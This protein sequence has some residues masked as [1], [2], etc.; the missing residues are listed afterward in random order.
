M[1]DPRVFT[2]DNG[3]S[4]SCINHEQ[5]ASSQRRTFFQLAGKVG[6]LEVLNDIGASS[7]GTGLRSLASISN[8]VRTGCGAQPTILGDIAGKV[9]D[10]VEGGAEWV[11]NSVGLDGAVVKAVQAFNPGVANRGYGAAK[12]IYQRV[13]QGN[14]NYTDIPTAMQDFQDLER[15][16]R[17]IFTPGKSDARSALNDVCQASPFAMDL[18]QRAPK[19]KFLFLAQFIYNT[20]YETGPKSLAFVI[21]TADR[22]D[23]EYVTQDVNFY[24]FQS[25]VITN[26]KFKEMSMTFHDDNKNQAMNFY[27]FY[28]QSTVPVANVSSGWEMSKNGMIL[29][30][31]LNS[32][33][34]GA[35]VGD[36]V[37]V[38]SEIRL[39]HI[40]DSG[41][42]MNV[43]KFIRPRLTSMDLDGLDMSAGDV[44]N[45][46]SIKFFYDTVYIED[47]VPVDPKKTPQYDIEDIS[48]AGDGFSAMFPMRY[49]D[50][51]AATTSPE[52][53]FYNPAKNNQGC[54]P[55]N[56]TENKSSN[57]S[58]TTIDTGF[59]GFDI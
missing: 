29:D 19:Y 44:G 59:G 34:L 3:T 8:S 17:S 18:V 55:L 12:Q 2:V 30:P 43:Y 39:F 25:K 35:L 22:P 1:A 57:T 37:S 14:F 23:I 21:K 7:I 45:E 41:Q 46:L 51:T 40:Y 58:N 15:L 52:P 50:D 24:N 13:K 27:N 42:F 56:T 6:D 33:N 47:N 4:S 28:R 20:G 10:G 9:L 36:V 11:L 16:G 5:M 53:E 49:V 48:H 54:N 38:F 32:S 31:A 26:S